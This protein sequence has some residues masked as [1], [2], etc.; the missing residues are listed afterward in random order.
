MTLP[1]KKPC[2]DLGELPQQ[3]TA[4]TEGNGREVSDEDQ[5]IDDS[6]DVRDVIRRKFLVTLPEDFYQFWEFCSGINPQDPIS[7]LMAPSWLC[8]CEYG[9]KIYSCFRCYKGLVW[10]NIIRPL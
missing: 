8:L 2:K 5:S 6:G 3:D 9:V 1:S 10:F 4:A 7:T